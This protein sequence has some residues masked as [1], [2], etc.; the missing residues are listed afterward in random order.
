MKAMNKTI[1]VTGAGNGI[2]RE[3]ALL[4]LEKGATV[5]AADISKEGLEKTKELANDYVNNIEIFEVDLAKRESVEALKDNVL[6]QFIHVDGFI[7]V[8]GIIQPFIHVN[9]LS[10]EKIEQVMNINFYGNVYMVKSFLPHFLAQP[11]A[12]IVN[13]SSMGGFVPVPGQT[14][15]GASKAAVKLLTEGLHSELMDTNV[16]VTLVLPGGVATD[17]SKN[18]GATLKIKNSVE[19]SSTMKLLSAKEAAAIIVDGMEK[20]KYHV[21]AGKD[22]KIL[23]KLSRLSP[24]KAAKMITKKLKSVM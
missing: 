20:D 17:I 8:A 11:E 9:D 21:L 10:Y 4:L 16:K 5:A 6:Q 18:S 1:V 2:G 24:K 23:H 3:V 13:V 14:I 15:Y 19:A 7:N 22:V 12:H